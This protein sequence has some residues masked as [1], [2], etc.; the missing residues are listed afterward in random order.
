MKKQQGVVLFFA[1]IVLLIMTVIGVALAVNSSQSL[2]MAG[3]GSERV[4]ALAAAQGAQARAI[5]NNQ[6]S[7]MANIDIDNVI[8]VPADATFPNASSDIVPRESGDVNCQRSADASST[9]LISC[10]RM[11]ITT[12]AKFGRDNLGSLTVVTGVEQEVLTGS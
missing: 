7:N 11:E 4:E 12:T 3:A 2:R 5:N 8:H 6:G 1:L 9:N 10:R